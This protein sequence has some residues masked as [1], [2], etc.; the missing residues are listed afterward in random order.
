[1]FHNPKGKDSGIVGQ[2]NFRK[3]EWCKK[4]LLVLLLGILGGC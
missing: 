3:G 1:M 2:N 4:L